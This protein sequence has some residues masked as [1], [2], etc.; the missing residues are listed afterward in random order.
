MAAAV[1][2]FA[3][4]LVQSPLSR[5]LTQLAARVPWLWPTYTLVAV[6]GYF[7]CS[8][9]SQRFARHRG[10][11]LEVLPQ[12]SLGLSGGA[13]LLLLLLPLSLWLFDC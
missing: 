10:E 8:V 13:G 5:L 6:L 9:G 1:A 3:V 11:S 12:R 2:L 4:Y 7:A